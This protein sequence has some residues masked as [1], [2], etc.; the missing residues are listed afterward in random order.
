MGRVRKLKIENV[1]SNDVMQESMY[2][3]F[4]KIRGERERVEV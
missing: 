4:T 3:F 2:N 1:N